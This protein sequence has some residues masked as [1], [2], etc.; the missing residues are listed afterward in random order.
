MTTTWM[1]DWTSTI[2]RSFPWRGT[3]KVISKISITITI[4]NRIGWLTDGHRYFYRYFRHFEQISRMHTMLV[5]VDSL[6]PYF[7]NHSCSFPLIQSGWRRPDH[8]LQNKETIT[9]FT[10]KISLKGICNRFYVPTNATHNGLK[11]FET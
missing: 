2:F 4:L 8:S 5:Y 6:N 7:S 1:I 10:D 11:P 9:L 3:N